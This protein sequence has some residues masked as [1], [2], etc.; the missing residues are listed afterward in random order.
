DL[1]RLRRA[2]ARPDTVVVHETHW[3]ATARHADVVL[4]VTTSLEREDFA[5]SRGDLRLRVMRRAVP[6]HGAARDEYAIFT[7]LAE[8]LGTVEEFTEGRDVRQWLRHLYEEWRER[9][10][11]EVE[12]PD[13]DRFWADGGVDIPHRVMD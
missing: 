1:A 8:R 5:A 2:F 6:P 7:G 12:L 9:Q 11:P 3:T 10:G 13:F 4:P